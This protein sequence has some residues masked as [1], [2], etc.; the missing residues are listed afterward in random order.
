MGT[1]TKKATP[2]NNGT[3]ARVWCPGCCGC[4]V[5]GDS[6]PGCFNPKAGVIYDKK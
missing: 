1:D 6:V 4:D 3:V 2:V 5:Y